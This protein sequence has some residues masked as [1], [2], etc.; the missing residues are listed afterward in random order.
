MEDLLS[1]LTAPSQTLGREALEEAVR[2][3]IPK[4]ETPLEELLRSARVRELIAVYRVAI[5][6]Y[7]DRKLG[8][9]RRYLANDIGPFKP[10]GQHAHHLG[11]GI[12]T[13]GGMT[14]LFY[15][16]EEEKNRIRKQLLD[17]GVPMFVIRQVH[18]GE[19]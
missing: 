12:E 6:E 7:T 18:R 9:R 16:A 10:R 4:Q 19:R 3:Y 14:T 1:E 13:F 11:F 5:G 15:R 2:T 8:L 17:I